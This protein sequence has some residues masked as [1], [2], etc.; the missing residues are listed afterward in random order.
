MQQGSDG[1][2]D[3]ESLQ[4][5]IDYFYHP[6]NQ[7]TT[8]SILA[9]HG[10]KHIDQTR[11]AIHR[12][13]TTLVQLCPQDAFWDECCRKL[14]DFVQSEDGEFFSKQLTLPYAWLDECHPLQLSKIQAE[15]D[16]IRYAIHVLDEFFNGGGH[17][18]VS[19][20]SSSEWHPIDYGNLVKSLAA[21]LGAMKP[22]FSEGLMFKDD[23]LNAKP[24][25]KSAAIGPSTPRRCWSKHHNIW[26]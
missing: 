4:Q 22:V 10:I 7:F 20:D 3:A 15:K 25:G 18:M 24:D 16:N 5:H 17:T 8:F 19:H 9:T 23:A 2:V 14:D 21:A 11:T 12:D 1:A 6:C 26:T 13:I